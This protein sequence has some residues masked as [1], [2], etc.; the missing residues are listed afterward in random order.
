M[1]KWQRRTVSYLVILWVVMIGY[2]ILYDYGM[3]VFEGEDKTFLHS[4]QVVVE[5]FTTTGFGSDAPW[6]TP[7]M[8]LFVILMDL[9]GVLL[10]FM[11]LPVLVFPLMEDIL[12]TTVPTAVESDVSDHVVICTFTARADTLISELDAWDV[13]AVIVEPDR[14]RA[15]DLYEDDY[16]V[17]HAD[18]ESVEGL[19]DAGLERASAL[20]ADVSDEVDASIVLTAREVEETVQVV[21][22]VEDP[23]TAPYHR[24]AGAD[25]VLSPRPLLGQSLASKVTTRLTTELGDTI[26]IGHDFEVAELPIHRKSRLVGRTLSESGIRERAGV[27]VIGAWFDGEF[28]SPLDPDA[29]LTSGTVLL[30]TGREDQLETL[31]NFALSR[32]RQ[33][34][35]GQ[36]IVVGYGQVG[37]TVVE[38][39]DEADVPHTVVDVQD[40]EGVDVVGDAIDPD[41]LRAAGVDDAS[42]VV[43]TLPDDT[44]TEFTSLVVRDESPETELIARVTETESIPKLYRAG[45]DYV[46]SLAVVSGRMIAS[47]VLEGEDVLSLDHQ[48][49]VIRTMAPALVGQTLAEAD[50]RDRTGCTVVG[51][52]RDGTVITDLGP[53]FRIE[54]GDELIVAGTDDGTNRFTELLC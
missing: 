11:A 26:E 45:A 31:K 8:N 50:V 25:E 38:R 27:N 39:L 33:F 20:V 54:A 43:L 19:E 2:A 10:I 40:K 3:L 36:T 46:L 41:T 51:V 14:E 48:V 32:I 1:D 15:V 24:L 16:P 42:S 9:T 13:D 18:P 53:E 22:V 17:I 34:E 23:E 47:T 37:R 7:E 29:T 4:L 35:R 6:E 44:T 21:S 12:S 49:D 30:V 28:Q 5:A 52:E